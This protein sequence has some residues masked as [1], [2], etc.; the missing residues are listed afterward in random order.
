MCGSL[1]QEARGTRIFGF[2]PFK[3]TCFEVEERECGRYGWKGEL[4][5][6]Q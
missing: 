3:G 4:G 2:K 5:Q 6:G 1:G